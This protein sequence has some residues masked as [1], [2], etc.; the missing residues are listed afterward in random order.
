MLTETSDVCEYG[1]DGIKKQMKVLQLFAQQVLFWP[2]ML[3]AT[4]YKVHTILEGAVSQL[5]ASAE[6][7]QL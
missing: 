7:I 1:A 4:E 6:G 5:D 2:N 3:T